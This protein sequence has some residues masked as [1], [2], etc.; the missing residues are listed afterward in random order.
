MTMRGSVCRAGSA[1]RGLVHAG[2][3]RHRVNRDHQFQSWVK[4]RKTTQANPRPRENEMTMIK[5]AECGK[6]ISDKAPACIQCGAPLTASATP[7]TA[8]ATN[9]TPDGDE[10]D[11]VIQKALKKAARKTGR[12]VT[13]DEA[14]T[15]KDKAKDAYDHA[16]AICRNLVDVNGDGKFDADDLKAAAEKAGLAWDKF[17][18]DLKEA[19]LAGGVAAAALFFIPVAGHILAAPVFAAT[20]AYFFIFAKLKKVGKK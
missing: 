10:R 8:E 6:D 3:G 13:P 20:T 1:R 19:L 16:V 17:D 7:P 11:N 4:G 18:P 15:L 2:D 9:V 5:C 12:E 14:R